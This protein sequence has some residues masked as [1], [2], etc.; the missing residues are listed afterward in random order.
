MQVFRLMDMPDRVIAFDSLPER[1]LQGFE[2]CAA[3]GFSREWKNFLGKMKRTVKVP[4][5]RDPFT[6]QMRSYAPIVEENYFFYLVDF[7]INPVVEKWEEV[8]NFVRRVVDRD[9]RLLDD[10]RKMAIPL[11]PN[12][13]DGVSILPE[14]VPV[15]PIPLQYQ[16][17]GEGLQEVN[18]III[19]NDV[20]K[21]PSDIKKTPKS[22]TVAKCN[23]C[24]KEYRGAS[25]RAALSLHKRKKHIE[26]KSVL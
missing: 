17:R 4:P 1:L 22:D 16:E 25:A 23:D 8:C 14:D 21:A 11:A 18:G 9:V 26:V 20:K 2:L 5:D 10:M 13:T 6:G 24:D 15:I 7:N 12:K 3:E 19:P